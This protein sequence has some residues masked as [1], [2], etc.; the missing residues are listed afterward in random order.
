MLRVAVAVVVACAIML[1]MDYGRTNVIVAVVVALGRPNLVQV[2]RRLHCAG[3]ARC[4]V[5]SQLIDLR[6]TLSARSQYSSIALAH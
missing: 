6:S 5:R 1:L 4:L 3:F 2:R